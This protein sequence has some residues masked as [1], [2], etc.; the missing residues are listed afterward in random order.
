M[1]AFFW[2]FLM[3]LAA[4]RQEAKWPGLVVNAQFSERELTDYLVTKLKLKFITTSDFQVPEEAWKIIAE[5]EYENRLI[6]REE[7]NLQP[8]PENWLPEHVYES[9]KYVFFPAFI[10]KFNPQLNRGVR[11]NFQVY[12]ENGKKERIFLYQKT[13]KLK[14]YPLEIPDVLYLDGW[15]RVSS[16]GLA[17]RLNQIEFWTSEKAVCLIK[18]PKN[19]SRLMIKGECLAPAGEK[20]SLFINLNGRL[21]DTLR[22]EQGPFQIVYELSPE[23]LGRDREI[24]LTLRVDKMFQPEIKNREKQL[25]TKVGLKIYTVY[26]KPIE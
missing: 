10:D 6:F 13:F 20:Q 16:F 2:F 9:E 15:E 7:F 18:N 5:G 24:R 12:A 21:L 26:L 11:L 8:S 19:P 17:D 14:P 1:W 4:C 22:L 25:N 23:E 3:S